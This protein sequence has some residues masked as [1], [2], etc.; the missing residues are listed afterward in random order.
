MSLSYIKQWFEM[1]LMPGVDNPVNVAQLIDM[2][3]QMLLLQKHQQQLLQQQQQQQQQLDEYSEPHQKSLVRDNQ[4]TQL[5]HIKHKRKDEESRHFLV[6][7]GF[8][9]VWV[10]LFGIV[11]TLKGTLRHRLTYIFSFNKKFNIS[12]F[13]LQK[14]WT[15]NFY[16]KG[17]EIWSFIMTL[18]NSEL[19]R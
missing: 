18:G 3:Q 11:W 1:M 16:R 5:E 19:C 7:S 12:Q 2:L 14:V 6:C 17:P 10:L 13:H 15:L 8:D 9:G 4:W